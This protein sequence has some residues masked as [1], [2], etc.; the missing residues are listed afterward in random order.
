MNLLAFSVI[1]EIDDF[2][3]GTLKNS[4][5][6]YLIEEGKINFSLLGRDNRD[7][8]EVNQA[9][10]SKVLYYFYKITQIVYDSFYFYF[11][12]FLTLVFTFF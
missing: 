4:L 5:L 8:L 12:S 1:A 7:P 9:T 11:C 6:L 2:Y 10:T 3:A